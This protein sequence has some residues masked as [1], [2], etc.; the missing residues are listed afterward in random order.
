M[1]TISANAQFFLNR[2]YQED[3]PS[4]LFSSIIRENTDYKIVGVTSSY[5]PSHWGR[6]FVAKID[7][8]GTFIQYKSTTDDEIKIYG[9]F[10]NSIVKTTRGEYAFAG[11][12][13]DS[14]PRAIL[15]RY[16]SSLDTI[17][18]LE[19]QTPFSYA[20]QGEFVLEY[21]THVFFIAG[22]RTDSTTLRSNVMLMKIDSV[23][24]RLWEKYYGLNPVAE[25]TTSFIKLHNGNMMIGSYRRNFN[26]TRE[27]SYT[28]LLEVDTGGTIV[29]QWLDPNDSTYGAYGL[30][31]T[32]DGGFI[33]S[34]QKKAEQFANSIYTIG[35]VVKMD[36]NFNKQWTY[37][38]G[39]SRSLATGLFDIEE[40]EDSSFI[41]CGNRRYASL[42]GSGVQSG[43]VVKLSSSGEV[44]WERTYEGFTTSSADN[45]LYDIDLLP[46]GGFIACGEAVG[47]SGQFGWILRLDSNGCEVENCLVGIDEVVNPIR[48][49]MKVYPNPAKDFVMV[50][51]AGFE[52]NGLVEILDIYGRI[53]TTQ[54]T[55]TEKGRVE[56]N[57]SGFSSG[58]YIVR[59]IGNNI[60]KEKGRF[61]IMK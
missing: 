47:D 21:D 19:Y 18:I 37:E 11:Y 34:A 31:Q 44:L 30:L 46:D 33:Y 57:T 12:S 7:S 58:L 56:I 38:G 40:L 42:P 51:Y 22:V 16:H 60:V 43:W 26:L 4:M 49:E 1:L 15:G 61:N 48:E 3:R 25:S 35:T 14:L 41:A 13:Y 23:G 52:N 10:Q 8:V 5:N 59:V 27:L 45:F 29:R 50:E 2:T 36:N 6:I 20:F 24:N 28:W 32:K 55:T 9:S 53:I 39:G 54:Q 17:Q